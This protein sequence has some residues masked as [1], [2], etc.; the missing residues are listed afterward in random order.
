MSNEENLPVPS[1][2]QRAV[3]LHDNGLRAGTLIEQSLVNL[4]PEQKQ[5]LMAKAA[6]EAL[7]LEV[8]SREQN[9]DYVTGK[10]VA[11]DHIE[12][13]ELLGKNG[14]LT[15][16]SVVSEIKT[17]AGKMRIESKSGATCFVASAAYDDPNHPDVMFLRWYRDT[18]L[19]EHMVGR[20]FIRWYWKVGPKLA[21]A[22][23]KVPALRKTSRFTVRKIVGHLKTRLEFPKEFG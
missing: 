22:V 9:I 18:V 2:N 19:K 10:K 21:I 13:W 4:N 5:Q 16:Q 17:G 23:K 12:T 8:K 7:R 11:E 1:E 14:K 15:R 3:K 20:W 6:E